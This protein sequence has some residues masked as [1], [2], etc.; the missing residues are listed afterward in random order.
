MPNLGLSLNLR[1]GSFAATNVVLPSCPDSSAQ[2]VM[3][4]PAPFEVRTLSPIGYA[5]YGLETYQY[6][7]EVVRYDG[8]AWIYENS[9]PEYGEL[10][11]VYSNQPRPWLVSWAAPYSAEKLCP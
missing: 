8:S 9:Q 1:S 3:Y 11:R 7:D 4:G 6:G 5:P 10:A 2:V